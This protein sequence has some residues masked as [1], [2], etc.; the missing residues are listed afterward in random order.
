M[1]IGIQTLVASGA[2]LPLT[3]LRID[4][5]SIPFTV[6]T[7]TLQPLPK[8][9]RSALHCRRL[10]LTSSMTNRTHVDLFLRHVKGGHELIGATCKVFAKMRRQNCHERVI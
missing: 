8:L 3:P 9:F 5:T 4:L 1:T 10:M 6:F 2:L 7:V